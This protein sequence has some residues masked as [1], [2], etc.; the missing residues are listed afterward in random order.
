[1]IRDVI[2]STMDAKG[3]PH[4]APKLL[5]SDRAR[6]SVLVPADSSTHANLLDVPYAVANFTDDT[7]LFAGCLTGRHIWPLAP[8]ERVRGVRLRDCL[9]HAELE[10][11]GQD[12]G[13]GGTWFHF[14][15]ILEMTHAP[16]RGFSRA[17]AAVMEG[18]AIVAAIDSQEDAAVDRA[19]AELGPRVASGGGAEEREAW[20]WLLERVARVRAA[21][22]RQGGGAGA[23]GA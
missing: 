21:R 10:L 12:A 13:E 17:K 16:F 14:A 3:R 1:M 7:R 6:W 20:A 18:V 8:P 2:L 9:A 15:P 4:I 19:L 11:T 22:A 5:H 23:A